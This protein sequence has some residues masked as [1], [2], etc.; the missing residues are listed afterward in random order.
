MIEAGLRC[1]PLNLRTFYHAAFE[2][3]IKGSDPDPKCRE[4][5]QLSCALHTCVLF[6]PP[7]FHLLASHHTTSWQSRQ[8]PVGPSLPSY[9]PDL[10]R[11]SCPPGR[12][13]HRPS[14]TIM[15]THTYAYTLT[16][17]CRHK[18]PHTTHTDTFVSIG[19]ETPVQMHTHSH[20]AL[21]LMPEGPERST[22]THTLVPTQ[23]H[24]HT[25]S[26]MGLCTLT[27]AC[28]HAYSHVC[29]CTHTQAHM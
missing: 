12:G 29:T 26:H 8:P 5:Q 24:A 4:P 3:P 6:L 22:L 7:L 14:H 9:S 19:I 25:C 13:T 18:Y 11:A 15:H 20:C 10:L 27:H 16:H 28:S 23:A 1:R 17:A 21:I 2:G